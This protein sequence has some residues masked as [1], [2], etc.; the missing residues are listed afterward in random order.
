MLAHTPL[1]NILLPAK[2]FQAFEIMMQ[3][4]SF[5]YFE[6]G[7]AFNFDFTPTEP[8]TPN[9]GWLGYESLN[10]VENMGSISLFYWLLVL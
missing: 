3:I 9:F 7:E 6:I 1:M 8:F 2:A 5:D 10:F 4:V